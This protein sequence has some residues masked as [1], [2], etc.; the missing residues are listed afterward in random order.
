MNDAF[1]V[2]DSEGILTYANHRFS[3]LLDYPLE[4]M[5]G[6]P[7]TSFLDD[8]NLFI[9]QN[10]VRMRVEGLSSQY[11]LDWTMRN[12]KKVHTIVSG[13]PLF[14]EDG[15]H[16]GSFA[17]VT[18]IS[19][20]IDAEMKYK[21][22]AEQS[23]Q[24]LTIIQ[25][26]QYV[27]VNPAFAFLVGYTVDE[28][29]SM[30]PEEG[31]D[32]IHPD[33]RKY[34]LQLASDRRSGI[35]IPMPYEYRFVRRDGSVRWVQAFSGDIEYEGIPALQVMLIDI[36]EAKSTEAR[37][38]SS[39]EMLQTVMNTIPE[40]VFWKDIDSIYLGCN[41]NFALVSG[42]DTPD[43]I[44]GK[45]D[46]DLA[47]RDVEAELFK[48]L[49]QEV[50]RTDR[51]HMNVISPQR[52]ADD[53]DAWIEINIVPL[54]NEED[55]VIGVLGTYHDIT[56]KR[57]AEDNLIKSEAKYRS[58]AEQSVQGITI[59]TADK[60]LYY[61]PAFKELVRYPDE[62]LSI[63]SADDV[64]D[65]VHPDDRQELRK[66]MEDKIAGRSVPPRYEYRFIRKSGDIRWVESFTSRVEYGGTSAVQ[67]VIVDITGRRESERE[68][69]VAKDRALLYLDLMGH[70]LA[71]QLQVILNSAALMRS[72]VDESNKESFMKVIGDAVRRCARIIEE[73]KVTEQLLSIPIRE[74]KLDEAIESTIKAMSKRSESITFETSYS[75][76]NVIIEADDFLELLLSNILMNAIEHNPKDEKKVWV[77]LTEVDIGYVVSIADN[78]M[79]ISDSVKASL[80]DTSRRFGGLGL[81]TAH[82][83]VEKY[84]GLIEIHDRVAGDSTQGAEFRIWIPKPGNSVDT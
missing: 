62:E 21:L 27:Y 78:G 36:T 11:E 84:N 30:S 22:L 1:G 43:N 29:L 75:S 9:L 80:F 4:D 38:R 5:I 79:G 54:H 81:H 66:R 53:R 31:W 45:T 58:L 2:I 71:Q 39:Q 49:D 59:L 10:N 26:D 44:V 33:D 35:K 37:L 48:A 42:V 47:W 23:I 63:M 57:I 8:E 69:R 6:K 17:V 65:L 61:N 14:G 72:A 7:I 77:E 51:P 46:F 83:I 34:L 19:W 64:W 52:Q 70:D 56:E 12:G 25:N 20:R 40:Y 18:D 24:G 73:A 15:S 60:F 67:T 68:L 32:L 13:T 16:Q 41:E 50:I 3:E 55:K 28:I 74:R 82:Y 76:R